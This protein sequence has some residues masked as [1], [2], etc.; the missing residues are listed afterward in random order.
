M[1]IISTSIPSEACEEYRYLLSRGYPDTAALKLVGDHHRLS[2]I[3]R[4]CLFRGI[5]DGTRA[6]S[7]I[8][9][10]VTVDEVRGSRLGIDLYNVL[11]TIETYLKGGVL[12]LA[13]DGATRDAAAVHG[14]WRR[15]AATEAALDTV[16]SALVRMGPKRIDVFLDSPVAHS[17]EL[18]ADLRDRLAGALP[19]S[20]CIVE[21]AP[22]ADWPLKRYTGIVASSD[23]VVLDSAERV[24]DLPRHALAWR[25]GF[26]P[27]RIGGRRAP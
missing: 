6:D 3:E 26:I 8:R 21:L 12:F 9:K 11:I 7:R 24:L 25:Y 17:G 4:N 19:G 14:S 20:S 15:S 13:D 27:E 18:A 16:L 22:C 1:S 23:S 5:I 2:R 10:M